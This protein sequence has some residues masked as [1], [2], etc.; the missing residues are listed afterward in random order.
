[1]LISKYCETEFRSYEDFRDRF[2]IN[3][4]DHFNFA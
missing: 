3:V 1:M 2:K 4:P